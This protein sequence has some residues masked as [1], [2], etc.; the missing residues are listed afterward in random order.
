M[1]I[2]RHQNSMSNNE[3]MPDVL[4]KKKEGDARV[5]IQVT[6]DQIIRGGALN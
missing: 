6:R 2:Y 4:K 5:I 3:G 1:K